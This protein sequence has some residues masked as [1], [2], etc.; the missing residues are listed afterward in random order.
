MDEPTEEKCKLKISEPQ[1][2]YRRKLRAALAISRRDL[3]VG[4]AN[5]EAV[6]RPRTHE[7]S[8]SCSKKSLNNRQMQSVKE[9]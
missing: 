9:A 6:E 4:R 2:L 8:S 1:H 7:R 5:P 3:E